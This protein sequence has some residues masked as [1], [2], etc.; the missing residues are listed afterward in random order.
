MVD[1]L[2]SIHEALSWV[3]STPNIIT[4]LSYFTSHA[5]PRF[6]LCRNRVVMVIYMLPPKVYKDPEVECSGFPWITLPELR[7]SVPIIQRER[8]LLHRLSPP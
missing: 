8:P 4:V 1:H 7:A 2:P 6:D 5:K 3:P